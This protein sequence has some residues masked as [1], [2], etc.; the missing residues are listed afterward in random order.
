VAQLAVLGP[1]ARARG[2][3]RRAEARG[4]SDA[5]EGLARDGRAAR[6]AAARRVAADG[7]SKPRGCGD[8]AGNRRAHSGGDRAR[9][10][11]ARRP[12]CRPRWQT[13]H[14]R[15]WRGDGGADTGASSRRG[16]RDGRGAGTSLSCGA[17]T[18]ASIRRGGAAGGARRAAAR[19]RPGDGRQRDGGE[20]CGGAAAHRAE[21][22]TSSNR[23]RGPARALQRGRSID[24]T[25]AKHGPLAAAQTYTTRRRRT[26]GPTR[27]ISTPGGSRS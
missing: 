2:G 19:G 9:T 26:R 25:L 3:L 6:R 4:R 12:G 27:D 17:A 11:A 20:R 14:G 15:R 21:A 10:A 16:E 5:A 7:W 22:L 8:P 1:R 23:T 24:A 13:E 18:G